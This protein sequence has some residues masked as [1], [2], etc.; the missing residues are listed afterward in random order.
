MKAVILTGGQGTRLRPLTVNTPKPLLPLVNKPFMD[1]IL[2]QLGTYGISDVLLTVGYLSQSFEQLYGDGSHLGINLT[3]VHE[4]EPLDTGGAIKNVESCLTPG[5]TFF[6][7]NGD[8]LT[9]LDL[10][11]IERAAAFIGDVAQVNHEVERDRLHLSEDGLLVS[12]AVSR[13]AAWR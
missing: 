12:P 13:I 11:A 3:Y 6:V 5:E 2:Y 10:D 9:D 4:E 8:I 1:H 7:L